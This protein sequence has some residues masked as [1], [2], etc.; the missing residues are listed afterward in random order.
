MDKE[1]AIGIW[2]SGVGGLT[3]MHQVA[4]LL[5]HEN[6]IYFG[7]TA[8]VPYG[9]KSRETIVRYSIENTIFLTEHQIKLLIV[10]CNTAVAQSLD[11][12]QQIFKIPIIGVVEPGAE[13]AV[14][15]T[16]N[17]HIAVLGT[18][19]TV[20]SKAYQKEIQH[21]M[22]SAQVT[23][24]ACPLLVPLVEE[25]FFSHPIAKSVVQHYLEE[26]HTHQVDTVV[27]GCTHY[28]LLRNVIAAEL[29][30][31][32][33]IVDPAE[34]CAEKASALLTQHHLRA[35]HQK[36]HYKY[37]VSDDPER[38]RMLGK[39]FSGLSLN[40]VELVSKGHN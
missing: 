12:L 2:D 34:A 9:G 33:T 36:P 38:F 28:P 4:R 37:F 18:R 5:P 40:D 30:K 27:L 16:R 11:R 29:G 24:I 1:L 17:G 32:I 25:C 13:K 31:G 19:G 20:G 39:E 8:R 3:V 21:R 7:D 14:Q 23:G 22:P 26:L 10:A 6:I 35:S 15:A